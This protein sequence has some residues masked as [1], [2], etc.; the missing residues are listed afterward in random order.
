MANYRSDYTNRVLFLTDGIGEATGMLEMAAEYT[1]LGV[2]V[3][4][5]GLGEDF[6]L[7]LMVELARAGGGSSRFVSGR[8]E[9]EETFGTDLDRMAVPGA[10][11][12]QM[13]LELAPDVTVLGTWGYRHQVVGNR[14]H[15]FLPTLHHRDY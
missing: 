5:I 14:I 2:N 13:V 7:E 11:D 1:E 10:R 8:E 6:N 3:S 12:L 15:Y 4:T 9:M